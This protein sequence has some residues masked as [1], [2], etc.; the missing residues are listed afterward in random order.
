MT[1][2]ELLNLHRET[3]D[4]SLEQVETLEI[5]GIEYVPIEYFKEIIGRNI[6]VQIMIQLIV[7]A[8]CSMNIQTLN[9]LAK[10][11]QTLQGTDWPEE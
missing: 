8:D 4:A 10:V 2:E 3:F 6:S 7:K 9:G 1:E 5:G 11:L